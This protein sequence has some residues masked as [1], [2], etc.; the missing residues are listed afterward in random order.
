[1]PEA[2]SQE[3]YIIDKNGVKRRARRTYTDEF[4]QRI[5]DFIQYWKLFS[6]TIDARI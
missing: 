3:K 1:M 5:V 2:L 6:E 4:K